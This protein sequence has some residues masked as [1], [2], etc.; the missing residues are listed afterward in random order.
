MTVNEFKAA[1]D[2]QHQQERENPLN[3]PQ[4]TLREL[5]AYFR[6]VVCTG[7]GIFNERERIAL[8]DYYIDTW[9]ELA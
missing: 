6:E 3:L 9:E 7:R 5:G 4:E 1:I 8:Q 2:R